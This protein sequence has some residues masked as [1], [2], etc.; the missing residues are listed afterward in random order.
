MRSGTKRLERAGRPSP[1]TSYGVTLGTS[2][3]HSE[4]LG[5]PSHLTS[6]GREG[7]RERTQSAIS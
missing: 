2:L 6:P 7:T 5:K 1:G 4:L 3:D